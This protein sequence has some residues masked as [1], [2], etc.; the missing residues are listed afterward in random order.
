MTG[1]DPSQVSILIIDD[2]RDLRDGCERILV[3]YGC[4]VSKAADGATGLE[5]M[6]ENPAEIVLLDLKMPG[7]DGLEV[8]RRLRESHPQALVIVIT[9][10]ATV[11]TA[12]EAMKLGAY[13]FL[14]KP[15]QPDQLRLTVGRAME[16]LSLARQTE[17]LERERQQTLTD[18]AGEKSRLRTVISAL[19]LGVLVTQPSGRVV[20]YNPAFCQMAGLA[21]DPGPG[22]DIGR[23]LDEPQVRDLARRASLQQS[24]GD[25]QVAAVEFTTR[26]ERCLL[27]QATPVLNQD[28]ESLG[29]VL[30]FTDVTP[31]RMLDEL[32]KEFVAKVSHELRS[33]LSTILLQLTLLMG[34]EGAVPPK[35][36]RHLLVRA[37]ERTQGLISFVRDLLDLSRLEDGG[38][39]AKNA[40]EVHLEKVLAAVVEGLA[41]QVQS[42]GMAMNLDLPPGPLPPLWADPVGLESIFTNLAANAVNYSPDGARIDLRAC[43]EGEAIKVTVADQG[44]GIEPEKIDLIFNKFYRIKNDKTRYV[45]GTGL[46]LPIVK[47][48]VDSLGGKVEVTSQL[49]Q[50]STFTVTLPVKSV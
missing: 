26:Q 27:V 44:F 8:L 48:V 46:G 41:P 35:G 23:Y 15:F 49:G 40:S 42:R 4:Q 19:P 16:R 37:R 2:E 38:G 22:E 13:D 10:Y 9:G 20:L 50:G 36:H 11:E 28:S 32:R 14:P 6:R 5:A 33:P 29:A 1:N 43:R 39:G 21:D 47:N 17:R 45:T 30:V 12:I 24:K 3:R 18:L 25:D 31:Y 34:E 7:M